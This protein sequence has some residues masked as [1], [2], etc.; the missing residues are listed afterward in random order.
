MKIMAF[1]DLDVRAFTAISGILLFAE[2]ENS[3]AKKKH[4]I[5]MC[6]WFLRA[7]KPRTRTAQHFSVKMSRK[8]QRDPAGYEALKCTLLK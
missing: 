5:S 3:L 4:A 8:N 2:M 7:V 1:R 6:V